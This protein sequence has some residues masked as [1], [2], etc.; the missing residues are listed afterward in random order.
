MIFN[1]QLTERICDPAFRARNR[2][3]QAVFDYIEERKK[4]VGAIDLSWRSELW[5]GKGQWPAQLWE[6]RVKMPYTRRCRR[7][8][9]DFTSQIF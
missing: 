4:R 8:R 3:A 2:V 9:I 5:M 6:N 7:R 1:A